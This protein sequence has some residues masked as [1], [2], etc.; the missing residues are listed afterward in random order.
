MGKLAFPK[1]PER[2]IALCGAWVEQRG[3]QGLGVRAVWRHARAQG[4]ETRSAHSRKSRQ[5]A[6]TGAR[7]GLPTAGEV[8]GSHVIRSKNRLSRSLLF[9]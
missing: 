7:A 3:L 5:V 8:Q 2:L 4:P 6:R 9:F 1:L